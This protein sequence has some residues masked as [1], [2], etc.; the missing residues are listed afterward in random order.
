MGASVKVGKALKIVQTGK[1]SQ[2]VETIRT[3]FKVLRT[4]QIVSGALADTLPRLIKV[5]L[6]VETDLSEPPGAP[7]L[8]EPEVIDGP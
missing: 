3:S 5:W 7:E 8:A 6:G 2:V 1:F 4:L